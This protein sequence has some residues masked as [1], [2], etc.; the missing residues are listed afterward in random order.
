MPKQKSSFTRGGTLPK[1]LPRDAESYSDAEK[2]AGTSPTPPVSLAKKYNFVPI[3]A[4]SL[5]P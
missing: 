2:D 4:Q 1:P 3:V 5:L